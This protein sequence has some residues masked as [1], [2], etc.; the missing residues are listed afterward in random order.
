MLVRWVGEGP[1]LRLGGGAFVKAC[2]ARCRLS[3]T[4]GMLK[5]AVEIPNY[6][7]HVERQ[8]RGLSAMDIRGPP[9]PISARVVLPLR[10]H[11]RTAST[12]V[13]HLPERFMGG[14]TE[15]PTNPHSQHRS[16]RTLSSCVA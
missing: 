4:M 8:T 10:R 12:A 14:R 1:A 9:E 6:D 16:K 3:K 15:G 7:R 2:A 5:A 11:G 13:D